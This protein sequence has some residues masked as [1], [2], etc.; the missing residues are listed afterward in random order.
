[1]EQTMGIKFQ[2]NISLNSV[3]HLRKERFWN[4]D[5]IHVSLCLGRESQSRPK[6]RLSGLL[7]WGPG[8]PAEG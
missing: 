4:G 5:Y 1:M 2:L 3:V 6:G 8:L 7:S